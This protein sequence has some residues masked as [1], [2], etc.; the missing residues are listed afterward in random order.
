MDDYKRM[1][2]LAVKL[3]IMESMIA[4]MLDDLRE[5]NKVLRELLLKHSK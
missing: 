5:A 2:E 3:G 1:V 4:E